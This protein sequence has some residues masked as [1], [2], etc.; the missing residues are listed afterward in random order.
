MYETTMQD[1]TFTETEEIVDHVSVI[2]NPVLAKTIDYL[3][4]S[5]KC[6]TF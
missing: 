5:A 1:G 2:F 4:P 6:I 3:I